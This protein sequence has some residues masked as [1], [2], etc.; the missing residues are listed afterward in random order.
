MARN[1]K[2]S[3][4]FFKAMVKNFTRELRLPVAFVKK[5]AEILPENAKLRTSSGETWN[6]EIEQRADEQ[7]YFTGGWNKF[8]EDAGLEFGEFIVFMFSEK[9]V[10]DISVFG[11]NGCEREI[12]CSDLLDE[13]S[14]SESET[15]PDSDEERDL[16]T[17]RQ[18][19]GRVEKR[20]DQI[21]ASSESPLY[22]ELFLKDHHRYRV[23]LR[24]EFSV[25]AG[26]LNQES[27][28][29][30]YVPEGSRQVVELDHRLKPPRYRTDMKNGWSEFRASN[31]LKVGKVY[32]FEF[33]PDKNII[34]VREVNEE[35]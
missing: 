35:S 24:K 9:S 2:S 1:P 16:N 34:L 23:S 21:A 22:F 20:T 3:R 14:E 6:V 12:S 8:A 4:S 7:Y 31:G 5:H 13:D 10:F 19:I 17:K 27:V 29:V 28:V 18:K 33:K 30:E 26:L 15:D 11:V 25:A 32:S